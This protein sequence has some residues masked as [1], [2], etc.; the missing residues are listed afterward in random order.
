MDDF[1][2]TT[3]IEKALHGNSEEL[4]RLSVRYINWLSDEGYLFTITEAQKIMGMNSNQAVSYATRA[5]NA[6]LDALQVGRTWYFT[7]KW[8]DDYLA[9]HPR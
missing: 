8:L 2:T 7:R 5:K 3:L 6:P 1:E 4:E 9:A